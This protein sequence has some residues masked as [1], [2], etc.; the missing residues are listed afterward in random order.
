MKVESFNKLVT[1][2]SSKVTPEN[3]GDIKLSKVF[4]FGEIHSKSKLFFST[5]TIEGKVKFD[6]L[7]KGFVER[8]K[9]FFVDINLIEREAK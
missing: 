8:L 5:V 2:D 6:Q 7:W 4:E 9:G 1:L 3:A